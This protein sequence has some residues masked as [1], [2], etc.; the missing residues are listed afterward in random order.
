MA[1]AEV[2][3]APGRFYVDQDG[4][5]HVN[6]SNLIVAG[7]ATLAVT[8]ALHDG[9]TITMPAAFAATLPAAT[10]SGAKYRFVQTVA[11]TAVTI[12]ATGAHMFGV[13]WLL[14][15]NSAAVLGYVAAGSTVVTFDGSTKGGL[16]GAI[17]EIEDVATN[18]LIVRVMSA[19]TGTEATPFS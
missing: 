9:A 13:A 14:S 11:A 19:A 17:V 4:I 2:G 1:A 3:H 5:P 16:K 18:I 12:T 10:G 15:D 7:G 6:G 8:A